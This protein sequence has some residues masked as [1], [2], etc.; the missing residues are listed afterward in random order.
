L[1]PTRRVALVLASLAVSGLLI[2]LLLG[3]LE[4]V[5]RMRSTSG[6]RA[7]L[8]LASGIGW[9]RAG[10]A[11]RTLEPGARSTASSG[12]SDGA[13]RPMRVIFT[14]DSFA[15]DKTW[16]DKT[17]TAMHER[18]ISIVGF[19]AG[20]SGYGT[21]QTLMQLRRLLPELQPDAVVILF[22]GWNDLR[23][24]WSFPAI[25][26]NPRMTL[27]PY[28]DEQGVIHEPSS[29]AIALKQLELWKQVLEPVLD[30][31]RVSRARERLRDVGVDGL[32]SARERVV[33]GYDAEESWRPFYDP[34]QQHGAFVSGAWNVTGKAFEA[35]RELCA[36]RG[37]ALL[38]VGIDN[39]FTVDKDVADRW[40]APP[41]QADEPLRRLAS[42]LKELGVDFVDAVPALRAQRDRLGGAKQFDGDAGNIA[43]H[44]LPE[45]EAA[46]AE[47]IVPWLEEV[48]R[49]RK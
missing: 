42:L 48:S 23:D 7:E 36:E 28:L 21:T 31:W 38:V 13:R 4:V 26:Y 40:L 11:Y 16:G 34:A 29:A 35:I 46:L 25:C 20:V 19:E 17:V 39:P 30:P 37:V 45:A 22:Y 24:N 18:G 43:G 2:V 49:R 14:G 3:A 9:E 6:A 12:A 15:H 5:L 8:R 47:A 41:M 1:S 44:L 27:R 10:S 33:L 32:A